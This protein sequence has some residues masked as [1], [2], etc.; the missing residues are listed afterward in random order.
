MAKG[1]ANRKE[2]GRRPR[3]I[4]LVVTEGET[5]RI[6]FEGLKQRDC[7]VEIKLPQ[8]SPTDAIN[9]VELS[10]KLV[11]K[12]GLDL[13][14]GDLA[15]CAFDVE[16]NPPENVREAVDLAISN[17]ITLAISNPCFELWYILH[18]HRQEHS[19]TR[20][21]ALSILKEEIE[22]YSKTED[23]RDLLE[24]KRGVATKNADGLWKK[25]KLG[26]AAQPDMPNPSTSVHLAIRLIES[27]VERNRAN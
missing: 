10:I 12:N 15:I 1:Y 8:T 7:N 4:V 24:K 17:G 27:L 11:K 23:Y 25:H 13:K 21:E 20:Q 19:I 3:N 9:L 14:D 26:S 6:L 18:F 5:E 16:D 22:D 2:E